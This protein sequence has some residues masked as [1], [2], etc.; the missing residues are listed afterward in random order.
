MYYGITS[1]SLLNHGD[2][3]H[4][5]AFAALQLFVWWDTMSWD[6]RPRLYATAA[7]QLGIPTAENLGDR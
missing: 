2:S 5:P 1:G 6:L 4:G 7:P 3:E